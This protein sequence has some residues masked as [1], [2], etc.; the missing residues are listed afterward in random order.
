MS[1]LS[2]A[3]RPEG[4]TIKQL[5]IISGKGGTGKTSIAAAF[6]GLAKNAVLADCDVDAADLHLILKPDIR[7]T[8]EFSGMKV[9]LKDAEKC[10]ECG[11]CRDACRFDAINDD[12]DVRIIDCEGCGVCVYVCPEDALTLVDRKSGRAFISDTRFGPLAHA[13]LNIAEEAS[14]KLVTLV[15]NNARI[16]AKENGNDL[17]II[18]GPPGIGCPV[19]SSISGVDLVFIVT[20]PTKS[21]LHDLKRILDVAEHFSIPSVV[22]VNKCDI[23]T[24]RSKSI[25]K[26]CRTNDIPVAGLIPYDTVFTKAMLEGKNVIEYSENNISEILRNTWQKVEG[27]LS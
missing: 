15:R 13:K 12:F 1:G 18:D 23:N 27:L 19:I 5:T 9:P 25:Q 11:E 8:M 7:K 6:A 2:T 4:D 14:G 26:F 16:L 24:D 22:C 10:V 17:I 20:E 3:T 21:G